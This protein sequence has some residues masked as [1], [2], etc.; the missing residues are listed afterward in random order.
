MPTS[1]GLAVA[2]QFCTLPIWV[3]QTVIEN[4]AQLEECKSIRLQQGWTTDLL[5]VGGCGHIMTAMARDLILVRIVPDD[6]LV[7]EE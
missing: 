3:E 2:C 7:P 6:G 5:H 4:L 1:R